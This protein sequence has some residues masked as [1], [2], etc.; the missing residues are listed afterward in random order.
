MHEETITIKSEINIRHGDGRRRRSKAKAEKNPINFVSNKLVHREAVSQLFYCSGF[1]FF[2]LLVC[3]PEQ[4][5]KFYLRLPFGLKKSHQQEFAQLMKYSSDDWICRILKIF[6]FHCR[7]NIINTSQ[8]HRN[9]KDF[10]LVMKSYFVE[11]YALRF[12]SFSRCWQAREDISER[13]SGK[14]SCLWMRLVER[15]S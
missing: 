3:G 6:S 2:L 9:E 1:A 8:P 5:A 13:C 11:L 10:P 4:F 12:R 14:S 7:K 15:E